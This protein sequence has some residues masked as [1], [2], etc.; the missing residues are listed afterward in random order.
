[1]QQMNTND[2]KK[3]INTTLS[4]LTSTFQLFDQERLNKVPFEGSWT[5]GQ[6][7]QHLIL[8]NGGFADVMNGPSKE[9]NRPVDQN[10]NGI[11]DSFLNFNIKMKSPEFIVPEFREYQKE[12][13][14]KTLDLIKKK[15]NQVIDEKNL[16]DTCTSFEVPVLGY[17]TRW[18]SLH[19]ILYHTQR[20]IHQ[21]KSIFG[22]LNEMA[23]I[24]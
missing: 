17:L 6:V 13:Q 21:L 10:V 24:K 9:T 14:L 20:H 2:L 11:R 4:D 5:G 18:E 7:I 12:K 22:K 3:E 23:S 16:T 8:S 15:I 1:M 19:F